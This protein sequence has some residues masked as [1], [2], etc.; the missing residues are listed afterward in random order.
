M[1]FGTD[2]VRGIIDKDVDT[3]LAYNVGKG[4]ALHILDTDLTKCVIIGKDTRTSCDALVSAIA[5]GLTD[6]GI[7]VVIVGIVSTPIVSFLVSRMNFG[8]G[9]MITASHNDATYNGIKLFS[10]LG[11]KLNNELERNIEQNIE[12]SKEKPIKKGNIIYNESLIDKYYQYIFHNFN[13]N[14]HDMTIVLD[15]ANG[16]NYKIAPYVFK[17]YKANVICIDCKNDGDNINNNCGAN[18][19]DNIVAQVKKHNA[20]FGFS[21]D[22]DGDRLRIVMSDGKVLNGDDLLY[23]FSICLK[24]EI[25]LNK[26]IAVGTIITN[27]GIENKLLENDIKLIRTDVGDKNIINKLLENNLSLGAE[28]SGHICVFKHNPTC[29]A[30]LNAILFL[31]FFL[32]QFSVFN[33]FL[34]SNPHCPSLIENISVSCE[35][36]KNFESNK[37]FHAFINNILQEEADVRILVRPS[38]TEPVIRVYVEGCNEVNNVKIMQKIIKKIQDLI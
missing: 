37:E 25:C 8:G 32:E 16:S 6:Y 7:D 12:I 24:N 33:E 4:Y 30:L 31:K 11:T 13:I 18:H 19:I 2:G 17:Q 10:E 5:C 1:I 27:Q 22:G 9:V 35:F 21:F 20:N 14:L 28:P 3:H 36:R 34:A 26:M 38:G 15:C 23:L 29:D